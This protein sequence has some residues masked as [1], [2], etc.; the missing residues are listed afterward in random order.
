MM[1]RSRIKEHMPIVGSDGRQFG[2]V[3]HLEGNAIK[4]TKGDSPDGRHHWIPLDWV[5]QVDD[6]VHVSQP[7]N[8]AMRD[9]MSNPPE[10]RPM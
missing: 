3:D 10:G 9:W 8:Q 2:M 4:L 5:N 6:R 7:S 1:D